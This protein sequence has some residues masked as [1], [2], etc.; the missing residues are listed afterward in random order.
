MT[1]FELRSALEDLGLTQRD[2]GRLSGANA[3]Q[4]WR[5]CDGF[6]P[7]PSYVRT[8]LTLMKTN[9]RFSVRVGHRERWEV[10]RHHV[11]RKGATFRELLHRRHPDKNKRDTNDEMK[12]VLQFR[13]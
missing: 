8:I 6:S 4:V 3:S 7:V 13:E 1:C 12:M 5:W 10:E 11:F 9:D 2:L